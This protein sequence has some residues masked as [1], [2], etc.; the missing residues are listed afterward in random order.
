M[1]DLVTW[2]NWLAQ[3][4]ANETLSQAICEA[5]KKLQS[6]T[7]Q[8]KQPSIP[9]LKAIPA[10]DPTQISALDL[11]YSTIKADLNLS[12][13]CDKEWPIYTVNL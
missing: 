8:N 7:H 6:Y 11:C 4:T 10:L 3:S 1:Q 12:D 13:N 2:L 5:V 9:L